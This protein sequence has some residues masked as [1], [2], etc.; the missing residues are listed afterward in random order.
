MFTVIVLAASFWPAPTNAYTAYSSEPGSCVIIGDTDLYGIGIRI[1]LYLQWLSIFLACLLSPIDAISSFIASNALTFAI[2]VSFLS[3]DWDRGIV[4]VEWFLVVHETFSLYSGLILPILSCYDSMKYCQMMWLTVSLIY[5]TVAFVSPYVLIVYGRK[6]RKDGCH[7]PLSSDSPIM[8]AVLLCFFASIALLSNF[9]PLFQRIAGKSDA[10]TLCVREWPIFGSRRF[11]IRRFR[12]LSVIIAVTGGILFI[13]RIET[14]LKH[15]KVDTSRAKLNDISQLI[16]FLTGL[17]NL[18]YICYCGWYVSPAD[19]PVR[20][21]YVE[22]KEATVILLCASSPNPRVKYSVNWLWYRS[23]KGGK[24]SRSPPP[25]IFDPSGPSL[26]ILDQ[27]LVGNAR[28][29]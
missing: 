21:W 23:Y 4:I 28:N 13:T 8:T 6:G 24:K 20:K 1:G 19:W 15:G 27:A 16:P 3:G 22:F 29:G 9:R 25:M 17:F 18:V 26:A 12:L 7:N 11:Q 5:S 14:T 2:F 10:L